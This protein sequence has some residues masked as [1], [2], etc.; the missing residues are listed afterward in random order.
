[1]A[2]SSKTVE[3]ANFGPEPM[4]T[5]GYIDSIDLTRALNWYNYMVDADIKKDWVIEYCMQHNKH[6][7]PKIKRIHESALQQ[8]GTFIRIT[9]L[10]G[11]IKDCN[12]DELISVCVDKH[13][14]DRDD[15]TPQ[16]NTT[17][18]KLNNIL[19]V[20][21]TYIDGKYTD[22]SLTFNEYN[23]KTDIARLIKQQFMPVIAELT[24]ALS[25]DKL[26]EYFGEAPKVTLKMLLR[27]YSDI[28][29]QCD[30]I[31]NNAKLTRVPRKIKVHSKTKLVS[32]VKYKTKLD[33][34]NIISINPIKLLDS[35]AIWLYNS[36]TKML[37]KY[38]SSDK[39]M[40]V[41]GTT[42]TGFSKTLSE[43]KR[44]RKPDVV[45]DQLRSTTLKRADGIFNKLTTKVSTPTG[46]INVD[47]IILRVK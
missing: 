16:R 2:K 17:K 34:M 32:K 36:K 42:I 25:D 47:T 10:G 44:V 31:L 38:I 46:R 23:V 43:A 35:S 24:D 29:L 30:L 9:Q 45:L 37:Q 21:E 11:N 12:I 14:V 4:Y 3:T 20:L 18:D 15:I 40:S 5:V 7:V 26:A 13:Y 1:M 41:K 28:I 39:G 6:I 27:K 22:V 8:I 33:D 19:C